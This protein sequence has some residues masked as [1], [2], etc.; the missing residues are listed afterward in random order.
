MNLKSVIEKLNNCNSDLPGL[1]AQLK[2][3]PE[4][5]NEELEKIKPDKNTRKSAILIPFYEKNGEAF[6]LM[7]KRS[8]NL[9]NHPGQISFPGGSIDNTDKDAQSAAIRE[10]EEELGIFTSKI[11]IIKNLSSLFIPPSNFVVYPFIGIIKGDFK[12]K[13]NPAEVNSVLRVPVKLFLNDNEIKIHKFESSSGI[14][15]ESPCFYWDNEC[16]WG[17]SAMIISELKEILL[18]A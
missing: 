5:R 3:A 14:L 18:K 1:N 12:I 7:T 15:R 11:E 2:M 9:N 16:I 13:T 17:A 6:T 8:M 4:F 10:T